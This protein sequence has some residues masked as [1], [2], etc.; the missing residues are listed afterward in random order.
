M[1]FKKEMLAPLPHINAWNN[2][3]VAIATA[4]IT[5]LAAA[6]LSPAPPLDVAAASAAPPAPP[7]STPQPKNQAASMRKGERM[8]EI[9]MRIQIKSLRLREW[10]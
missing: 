10:K 6:K 1:K 4:N 9:K 8:N 7:P 3:D 2:N 5:Y